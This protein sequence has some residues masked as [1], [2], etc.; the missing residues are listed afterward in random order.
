MS[1]SLEGNKLL[2]AVLTAGIMASGAGVIASILYKPH[3]LEEPVYAVEIAGGEE[4]GS[5]GEAAAAVPLAVLLA[6]ADA[7]A[8]EKDAKKCAACHSFDEG[9]ADK[10]G[11][12]LHGIVGRGI[13]SHG[14]FAYSAGM[15]GHG[16]NWGYDELDAFLADP[17]GYIGDT[18]M[19]FAGLRKPEDRA[20]VIV[21]LRSISPDAPPLPE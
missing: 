6:S 13:G 2:A 20:N 12:G 1:S 10:V 17:K 16:G 21:Y 14:G 4:G 11:P 3:Q 7:A 8:G 19:S 9:G 15:A 18:K 5:G